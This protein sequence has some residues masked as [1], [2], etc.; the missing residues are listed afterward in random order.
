MKEK[1]LRPAVVNAGNLEGDG[2]FPIIAGISL[3]AGLAL[4]GGYAAGRAVSQAVKASPNFKLPSLKAFG[5]GEDDFCM[6]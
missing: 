6:A 3:K 2:A 4:L 1:Y 5:G